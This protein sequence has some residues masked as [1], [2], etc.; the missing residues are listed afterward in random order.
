[1]QSDNLVM[2]EMAPSWDP[3]EDVDVFVKSRVTFFGGG[4]HSSF[5]V[6]S[7]RMVASSCNVAM[8]GAFTTTSR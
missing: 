6:F 4:R 3:D 1:M 7:H 8:V 5:V 2:A